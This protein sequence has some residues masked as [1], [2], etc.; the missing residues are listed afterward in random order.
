MTLERSEENVKANKKTSI[1]RPF[2]KNKFSD[3][4][5]WFK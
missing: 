2:R 4:V 5:N 3:L 1:K